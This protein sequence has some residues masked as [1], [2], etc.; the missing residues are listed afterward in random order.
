MT[1]NANA[2]YEREKQELDSYDPEDVKQTLPWLQREN[3]NTYEKLRELQFFLQTR[4]IEDM[5][6]PENP[7]KCL[8][9]S[10]AKLA[11]DLLEQTRKNLAAFLDELEERLQ[12]STL[13]TDRDNKILLS[14]EI[15]FPKRLLGTKNIAL[16]YPRCLDGKM[17]CNFLIRESQSFE[18]TW[19]QVHEAGGDADELSEPCLTAERLAT[20]V[21]QCPRHQV[22]GR[23][24]YDAQWLHEHIGHRFITFPKAGRGSLRGKIVKTRWKTIANDIKRS[25]LGPEC[26]DD[27]WEA[28]HTQPR[29]ERVAVGVPSPPEYF[30]SVPCLIRARL[31]FKNFADS[32]KFLMA[33]ACLP[34]KHSQFLSERKKDLLTGLELSRHGWL[35]WVTDCHRRP[36]TYPTFVSHFRKILNAL[37][38]IRKRNP[39]RE[40]LSRKVKRSKDYQAGS[41]DSGCESDLIAPSGNDNGHINSV[42]GAF[43]LPWRDLDSMLNLFE[44]HKTI[45]GLG[46]ALTELIQ[47]NLFSAENRFNDN[48]IVEDLLS[49]LPCQH[50]TD[51]AIYHSIKA[52]G[53]Q[54]VPARILRQWQS[55]KDDGKC[56]D[57]SRDCIGFYL[58]P[59]EFP[60]NHFVK[61][62]QVV[63]IRPF[64][65]SG[66]SELLA[67]CIVCRHR[68][69]DIILFGAGRTRDLVMEDMETFKGVLRAL[70]DE[71]WSSEPGTYAWWEPGRS[72]LWRFCSEV[73][74]DPSKICYAPC[75]AG[76]L[77]IDAAWKADNVSPVRGICELIGVGSMCPAIIGS[78]S[79]PMIGTANVDFGHI[80]RK[81]SISI[82]SDMR[83]YRLPRRE[84]IE[85]LQK[86]MGLTYNPLQESDESYESDESNEGSLCCLQLDSESKEDCVEQLDIGTEAP[87]MHKAACIFTMEDMMNTKK[88]NS[89]ILEIFKGND[90]LFG[91]F[92]YSITDDKLLRAKLPELR[93]SLPGMLAQ[94]VISIILLIEFSFR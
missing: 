2:L 94:V 6:H 8:D 18:A 27:M 68:P 21:K 10:Q 15:K 80:R 34:S 37:V 14:D 22:N 90:E 91:Y 75:D 11:I 84:G 4:D 32:D 29:S 77:V 24:L 30:I 64:H 26:T 23:Y 12:Q 55:N 19:K 71:V 66:E 47:R 38:P 33:L 74:V 65:F 81:A 56:D 73:I 59:P 62:Y 58:R 7:N 76:V 17:V 41:L 9:M 60:A 87:S 31:V 43:K 61:D 20:F 25:D 54:I 45:Q 40:F 48:L 92:Q 13:Q 52:R 39:G 46:P 72:P 85:E 42:I 3:L 69:C 16:Y 63:F 89:R 35:Y 67:I 78:A 70:F 86:K 49:L 44:D 82:C 83:K 50:P 53:G 57:I 93:I 79:A 36:T 1:N 5:I 88:V 28:F 51:M